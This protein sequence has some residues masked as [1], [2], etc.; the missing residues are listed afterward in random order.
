MA[1]DKSL[2]V[3]VVEDEALLAMELCDILED[4]GHEILGP[5]PTVARA[6][7]LLESLTALPDAAIVDVNLSGEMSNRVVDRLTACDVPVVVTS[8]Y[9]TEDLIRMGVTAELVRKPYNS[10]RIAEAL[11]RIVRRS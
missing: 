3:F 10:R 11:E 1:A 7:A 8:G 6:L 4:L 5:V 9:D 2:R